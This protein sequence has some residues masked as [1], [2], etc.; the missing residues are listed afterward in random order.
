MRMKMDRLTTTVMAEYVH[1][2][3]ESL[4]EEGSDV[5]GRMDGSEVEMSSKVKSIKSCC[6]YLHFNAYRV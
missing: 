5:T 2:F 6:L 1:A 3:D 4:D